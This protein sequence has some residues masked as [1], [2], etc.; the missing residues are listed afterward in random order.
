MPDTWLKNVINSH[1]HTEVP[2]YE[3]S[4]ERKVR[5]RVPENYIRGAP[6]E[7]RDQSQFFKAVKAG[8]ESKMTI[9]DLIEK[10]KEEVYKQ[11]DAGKE[12]NSAYANLTTWYEMLNLNS[13][14]NETFDRVYNNARGFIW[15]LRA[16]YCITEEEA[17]QLLEELKQI[18]NKFYGIN[19]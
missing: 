4:P 9:I 17:D 13:I 18:N 3:A 19:D 14:K 16:T 7:P 15:G 11:M 10:L 2:I 5:G 12:P 1:E 8:K 6:K